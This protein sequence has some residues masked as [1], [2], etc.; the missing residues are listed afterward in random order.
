MMG[1]YGPV[2]KHGKRRGGKR[3]KSR[4]R[5]KEKET[6]REQG[7]REGRDIIR[8]RWERDFMFSLD[9]PFIAHTKESNTVIDN[10]LDSIYL[11]SPK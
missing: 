7:E 11:I 1:L 10:Y 3:N 6:V 5:Q 9:K 4:E 8:A 2:A